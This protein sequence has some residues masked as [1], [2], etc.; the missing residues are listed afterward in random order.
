V[1]NTQKIWQIPQLIFE[2]LKPIVATGQRWLRIRPVRI[3]IQ[4]LIL[5]FSIFYLIRSYQTVDL[6]KLELTIY[7]INL[8]WSLVITITALFLGGLGWWF[9]LRTVDQTI[10]L[11]EAMRIHSVSNLAKYLPGY[12]WQLLSKGYLTK[13]IGVPTKMI[14]IAMT[15]ELTQIIIGGLWVII[16]FFPDEIYQSIQFIRESAFFFRILRYV[17]LAIITLFPILLPWI[18]KKVDPRRATVSMNSY[19][20][21]LA[22]GSILAGWLLFG[23][24][25]WMIGDAISP[26]PYQSIPIFI[27]SLAVSFLIGFLI[28]IIPASIG[29]RESLMVFLLGN[30]LTAP[31]A[32][33]VAAMSRLILTI[34]ELFFAGIILLYTR[35]SQNAG[36]DLHIS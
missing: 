17:L 2:K 18:I 34:S 35:L 32:V 26:V 22:S 23:I 29:V 28:I 14:G 8:V 6:S 11:S 19:Q 10:K 24:A 21:I 15:L 33:I 7:S 16:L 36:K 25:F 1:A 3:I 20:L 13:K 9:S 12:A 27:F 31:V 5:S 4:V 30:L